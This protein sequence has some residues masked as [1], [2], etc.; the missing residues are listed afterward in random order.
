MHIIP[1]DNGS[2]S[3]ATL[4]LKE[5]VAGGTTRAHGDQETYERGGEEPQG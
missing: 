1:Y 4:W 2:P 5:L 3:A